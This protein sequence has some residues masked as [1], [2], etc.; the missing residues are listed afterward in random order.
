[1]NSLI[2]WRRAEDQRHGDAEMAPISQMRWN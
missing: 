2:P 1:M